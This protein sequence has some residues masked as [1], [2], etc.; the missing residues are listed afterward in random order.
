MNF[1]GKNKSKLSN[2]FGSVFVEFNFDVFDDD[3]G[4]VDEEKD[5]ED[6]SIFFTGKKKKFLKVLKKSGSLF[7]VVLLDEENEEVEFYFGVFFVLKFGFDDVDGEDND[8]VIIFFGKKKFFKKKG[9]IVFVVL[10]DDDFVKIEFKVID[11]VDD[12]K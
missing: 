4:F 11:V 1:G 2:K 8:A 6:I 10:G 5:V 9:S 7:S 3:M 12:L